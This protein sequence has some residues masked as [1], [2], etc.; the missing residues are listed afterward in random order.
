MP[1]QFPTSEEQYM[2]RAFQLARNGLGTVSSNPMVGCVIVKD[3]KVIGEG[4]HQKY[5]EAHAEV[6][7]VASV[8]D[9][10]LLEGSSVYVNLEPCSHFGKT[11]PCADLLV[12]EK[13]KKVVISNVDSNPLVSGQGIKKLRDNG[14][15]VITGVCERDG[16]ELNKRF[17]T[18]VEKKRPYI[19]LKWA[20][21]SDGFIARDN[22]DSKWISNEFSR[23]LVH[24]WRTEEDAVLVGTNT[25]R[26]DNPLLNVRHWSGRNP[27]RI[28]IDRYLKLPETLNLFDGSQSTICYNTKRQSEGSQTIFAQITEKDFIQ[29]MLTDLYIR[30]IQ[31]IIIEGGSETLRAFIELNLWDEAR[32]F[33]SPQ[34]FRAGIKGPVLSVLHKVEEKIQN[35]ILRHY[36]NAHA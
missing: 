2:R 36:F 18:F 12:R 19:I 9:K 35:D 3:S 24:K 31:S 16:R 17:F 34:E 5:G 29:R 13:V 1:D 8:K 22:Y 11:P 25:A 14:I 15:E 23:Q 10:T 7:A 27:T 28:V 4:W 30:K 20:Q 33:T 21:T 6:N 26:Q 32:V